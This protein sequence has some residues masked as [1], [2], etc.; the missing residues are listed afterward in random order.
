MV[1]CVIGEVVY[2]F[3][4]PCVQK[5]DLFHYEREALCRVNKWLLTLI[6]ALPAL[7]LAVLLGIRFWLDKREFND[8]HPSEEDLENDQL[9]RGNTVTVHVK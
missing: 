3:F 4:S 1:L 9:N 8:L 6:I 2:W 7:V 5:T